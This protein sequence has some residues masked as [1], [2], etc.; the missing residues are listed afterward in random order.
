MTDKQ[1]FTVVWKQWPAGW[2]VRYLD[3][4]GGYTAELLSEHPRFRHVTSGCLF[5]WDKARIIEL[6]E[7]LLSLMDETHL[8]PASY[9]GVFGLK[10]SPDSQHEGISYYYN[11]SPAEDDKA[12]LFLEVVAILDPYFSYLNFMVRCRK[13]LHGPE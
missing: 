13:E 12:R 4:N 1:L 2:H 9:V 7:N 6:G 3:K 11:P 10:P 8:R 5:P